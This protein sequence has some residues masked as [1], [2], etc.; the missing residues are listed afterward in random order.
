MYRRRSSGWTR[1]VDFILLD[2]IC[3]QV[4]FVLAYFIRHQDFLLYKEKLYV[5]MAISL[6]LINIVVLFVYGT[7]ENV[8]RRGY[9]KEF[10]FTV[11]H[12][13]LVELISV[14]Y[15]FTLQESGGYS[16][17]VLY[18]SGGIYVIL[19]YIVRL[20][21]KL[22]RKKVNV[23][24][25]ER[26]LLIV[27]TA[28]NASEAI[29][30]IQKYQN[31][32][33]IVGV[34]LKDND[35]NRKEID[36][37][38]VVAEYEKL[39]EFVLKQWVDEV[40][41]LLPFETPELDEIMKKLGAMGVTIHINLTQRQGFSGGRQ[42]VERMGGYTVITESMN[43]ASLK[44]SFFKRGLD[45]VGGLVGCLITAIL[46]IIVGPIIYISSPGPIFFSQERVGRNGKHFKI[47]KFRSMYPDAE[48]RKKELMSQNKIQD[49]MMFKMDF[50]PRIIGNKI[51]LDGRK[52]TGIGQ[53]IRSTSIDEFPQFFNVLKG[54][55]SLVGTRPPTVDEWE[56]YELHHRARLSV[57]PG[58]TGL[59][60]VS[61]RSSITDFEEVVKL[62]TEYIMNWDIGMDLRILLKTFFVVFMKKG[63]M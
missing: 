15:L 16:R 11:K 12:A 60:Q 40:F 4:A 37:I 55:M 33:N 8:L 2:M 50:D 25:Q 34:V 27:T 21:W 26:S 5:S 48:E 23:R 52:K 47:Y 19:T 44:E 3:L 17:I 63:S 7:M 53:F 62:D 41:I 43:Y 42:I 61:G 18:L 32:Y 20:L 38:P 59:W 6:E 39:Q 56:K 28:D 45:I 29:R 57:K 35:E 24:G 36:S 49:G 1:Y 54:D 9:F 10:V 51:L 46:T 30:N 14:L 13:I 22:V 31:D 58:I